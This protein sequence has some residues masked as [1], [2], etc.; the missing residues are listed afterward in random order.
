MDGNT[1]CLNEDVRGNARVVDFEDIIDG[2][3]ADAR[4]REPEWVDWKMAKLAMSE[5][6]IKPET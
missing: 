2:L 6:D 4:L 3:A 5:K 1:W